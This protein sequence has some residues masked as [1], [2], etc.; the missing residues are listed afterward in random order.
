MIRVKVSHIKRTVLRRAALCV[1]YPVLVCTIPLFAVLEMLRWAVFALVS[2]TCD[3]IILW[4]EQ[5][6][7]RNNK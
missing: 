7:D 4:R 6:D 1:V 3:A 2:L 5:C